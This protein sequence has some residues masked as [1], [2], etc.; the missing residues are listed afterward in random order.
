MSAGEKGPILIGLDCGATK[1]SAYEVIV[2]NEGG[3]IALSLGEGHGQEMV[4]S[5]W[6][7]PVPIEKQLAERDM[8]C[9]D[10]AEEKA[11][12]AWIRA[13]AR[14]VKKAANGRTR[15]KLGV[16]APGLKTADRR[17]ITVMRNGPRMPEF[18]DD[19][20]I[21]L[22]S[23][24]VD[25]ALPIRCLIG[26]GEACGEGERLYENGLLRDV[27]YAYYIGAGTGVAEAMMLGGVVYPLDLIDI[28]RAWELTSENGQTFEDRISMR[29]VNGAFESVRG[30]CAGYVED[31]ARVGDELAIRILKD[32]AGA[33]AKL[34]MVRARSLATNK[35]YQRKLQRVVLGQH[36]G[37]LFADPRLYHFF[38]DPLEYALA[39]YCGRMGVSPIASVL[40]SELRAAPAIGA[41]HTALRL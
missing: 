20:C 36:A 19:V 2:K 22:T 40:A 31:A 39:D 4:P 32:A 27:S 28:P 1:L 9:R 14:A 17:G 5:K 13:A 15:I 34:V 8:P 10:R 37:R 38:R 30:G 3:R 41:A 23:N 18:A 16:C 7:T 29:A 33:I 6:F 26:D 21:E 25:L 24:G 35:R 12:E 11:G